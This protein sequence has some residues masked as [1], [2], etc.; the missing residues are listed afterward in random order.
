MILWREFKIIVRKKVLNLH[1][2]N[3]NINNCLLMFIQYM[4][5]AIQIAHINSTNTLLCSESVT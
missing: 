3:N 5:S 4:S 1:H 2:N